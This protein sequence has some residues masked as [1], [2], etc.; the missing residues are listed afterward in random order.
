[1]HESVQLLD[2]LVFVGQF[3]GKGIMSGLTDA[4]SS[5]GFDLMQPRSGIL[6]EARSSLKVRSRQI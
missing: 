1:M 5:P 2:G 3:K 6:I 4:A